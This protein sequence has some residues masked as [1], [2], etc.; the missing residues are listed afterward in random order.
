MIDRYRDMG[1]IILHEKICRQ[2]A[3]NA[4]ALI[5]TAL[6][7]RTLYFWHYCLYISSTIL[8]AVLLLY[9]VHYIHGN[10]ALIFRAL[11]SWLY[12]VLSD[13]YRRWCKLNFRR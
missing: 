6:I 5:N 9:F 13:I 8:I 10:A 1:T 2:K 4:Y 12:E 11:C 7:F 3:L